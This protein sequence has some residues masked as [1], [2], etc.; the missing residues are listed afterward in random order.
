MQQKIQDRK[1]LFI[2][3]VR[4]ARHK[5]KEHAKHFEEHVA[6]KKEEFAARQYQLIA[7]HKAHQKAHLIQNLLRTIRGM[8]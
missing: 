3:D 4:F 1:N 6:G 7:R 5:M 8:H 2:Y